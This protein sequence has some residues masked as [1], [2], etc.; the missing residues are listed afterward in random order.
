V[1]AQLSFTY[2]VAFLMM[3]KSPRVQIGEFSAINR[4][5]LGILGISPLKAV[6]GKRY[7]LPVGILSSGGGAPLPAQILGRSTPGQSPD[8]L[9]FFLSH[10]LPHRTSWSPIG[11]KSAPTSS[12]GDVP[13]VSAIRSPVTDGA[14]SRRTMSITTGSPSVAVTVGVAGRPSRFCP[15]FPSL[16]PTTVY[17]LVAK[18]CGGA[19]R[20]TAP[21]KRRRRRSKTLIASPIPPPSAAGLGA[22]TPHNPLAPFFAKRSPASLTGWYPVI[23]RIS[24]LC[25]G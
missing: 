4:P 9:R 23:R 12:C 17:W 6:A 18:H 10:F 24:K 11:P 15:R 25:L 8:E 7:S 5:I 13:F 20:S 3:R 16:T 21:G 2:L 19:L 22:W 1:L 14:A